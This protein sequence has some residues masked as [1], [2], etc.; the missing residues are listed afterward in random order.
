[1]SGA[2]VESVLKGVDID[3]LLQEQDAIG[4][5]FMTG[6]DESMNPFQGFI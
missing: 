1:M 2:E 5:N 4:F 6:M 3:N